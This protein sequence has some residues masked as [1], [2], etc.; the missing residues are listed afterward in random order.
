MPA[1]A[2]S[3]DM[4]AKEL[5]A[6][7]DCE[8]RNLRVAALNRRATAAFAA[9]SLATFLLIGIVPALLAGS[10]GAAITYVVVERRM[11]HEL[12]LLR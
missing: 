8:E 3:S 9:V 6:T 1:A 12:R 10:L 5:W 4:K 7:M 11:T 2:D